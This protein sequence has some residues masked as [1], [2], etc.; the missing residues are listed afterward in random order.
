MAY[1][2]TNLGTNVQMSYYTGV[3]HSLTKGTEDN[4]SI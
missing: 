1:L 3:D 2:L 4:R